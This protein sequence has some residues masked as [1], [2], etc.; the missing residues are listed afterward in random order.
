MY[1]IREVV[2]C[3]PGKVAPLVE[4]FKT[5]SNALRELG[6]EPFRLMTDVSGQ[7][8]WTLVA[9]TTVESVEEFFTLEHKLREN[10]RVRQA[11]N[12]YHDLV[13]SGRR[14]IYRVEG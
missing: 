12:G 3:K 5:L 1:L 4:R 14:E 13:E 10:E 7:P 11:M 8:F 6:H 2:N 9:E